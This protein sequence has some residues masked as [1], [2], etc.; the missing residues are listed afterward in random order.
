MIDSKNNMLLKKKMCYNNYKFKY[1]IRY[2]RGIDK[3]H[4]NCSRY[5]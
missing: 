3:V 1:I 4:T 2:Y 5:S